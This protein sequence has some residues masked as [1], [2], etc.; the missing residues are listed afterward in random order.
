M[1]DSARPKS[2]VAQIRARFDA[3]VDRFS[4][5]ETGQTAAMDSVLAQTLLAQAAARITPH[6]QRILDVGCGAGN[7]TLRLL[8]HLPHREIVLL[9]LSQPMLDRATERIRAVSHGSIETVCGDVREL[10]RPDQS[11]D[12]ILAAAVLH[13][14][15]TDAE[16]DAVFAA[17][18]R[19]LRPGGSVW[20]YDLVTSQIPELDALQWAQYRHY[21]TSMQG[22]DFADKVMGYIDDED[23]PRPLM[24]QLDRLRHAGF[25]QVDVVHRHGCF[26]AFGAIRTADSLA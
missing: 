11:L 8:P 4:N 3:D 19:W 21:L 18:H 6:A 26:A 14:L 25:A 15:R 22:T 23:T 24:E 1:T 7:F 12:I 17:F 5:L 10:H 13:H 20:I 9:D 2:S 16:W